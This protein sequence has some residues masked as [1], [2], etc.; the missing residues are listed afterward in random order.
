MPDTTRR[1]QKSLPDKLIALLT[2]LREGEYS[3]QE[4][5]EL[6]DLSYLTVLGYCRSLHA[7]GLARIAKYDKDRLGRQSVVIY[8]LNVLV[9]IGDAPRP[10]KMSR[11]EQQMRY[12]QRRYE[13][14]RLQTLDE[15]DARARPTLAQAAPPTPGPVRIL[16]LDELLNGR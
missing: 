15:I 4:L 10:P 7:A 11:A 14:V 1:K 13:R 8:Q 2:A 5:A 12:R 9:G 6:T 16:T 3:C